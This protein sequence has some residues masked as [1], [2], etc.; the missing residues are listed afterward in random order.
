M[1]NRRRYEKIFFFCLRNGEIQL[2]YMKMR[3]CI[4]TLFFS[5]LLNDKCDPIILY[6]FLIPSRVRT[7]VQ[8][9]ICS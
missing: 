4:R 5:C 9:N 1:K 2:H 3:I 8:V 7:F 6:D